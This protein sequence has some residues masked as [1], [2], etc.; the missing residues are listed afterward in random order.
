MTRPSFE[1]GGVPKRTI[2]AHLAAASLA[3]A[4]AAVFEKQSFAATDGG[5]ARE[6]LSQ[7][8]PTLEALNSQMKTIVQYTELMAGRL[9]NIYKN[10]KDTNFS[11][12]L[13]ELRP[14]EPLYDH[15]IMYKHPNDS[16]PY[17]TILVMYSELD[18]YSKKDNPKGKIYELLTNNHGKSY[19]L[20]TKE[21]NSDNEHSTQLGHTLPKGYAQA[22][23][24]NEYG[25]Y[26]NDLSG[27][28]EAVD[29]SGTAFSA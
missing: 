18:F 23:I 24:V 22:S 17:K 29:S 5:G 4:A 14:D 11:L 26:L 1:Q 3:V 7:S 15:L 28:I 13:T 19:K 2:A 16:I 27:F 6:S 20:I 25:M 8:N 9:P 21:A 12:T 10:K